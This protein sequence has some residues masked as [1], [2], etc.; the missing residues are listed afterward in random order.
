MIKIVRCAVIRKT[1]ICQAASP[2]AADTAERSGRV[3]SVT[4]VGMSVTRNNSA[5]GS[6]TIRNSKITMATMWKLASGSG[7]SW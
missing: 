3:R 1:P 4:T 5:T 7:A 2:A 6:S